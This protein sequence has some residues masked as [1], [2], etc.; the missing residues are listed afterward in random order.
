MLRDLQRA[1]ELELS[2]LQ[3]LEQEVERHD[4]GQRRRMTQGIGAGRLQDRAAIA[5]DDD[6]GK[7]RGI[8]FE[9]RMAVT[10]RVSGMGVMRAGMMTPSR[11]GDVAGDRK[12]RGNRSARQ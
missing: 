3:T 12:G 11:V 10:V 6:R 8:V 5:V 7:R 2:V 1:V 9:M 4:F